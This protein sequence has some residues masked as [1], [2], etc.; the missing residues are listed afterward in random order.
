MISLEIFG[1]CPLKVAYKTQLLSSIYIIFHII[2][3][4]VQVISLQVVL[5]H[6]LGT[7][8]ENF[9]LFIFSRHWRIEA[10]LRK[11]LQNYYYINLVEQV[12]KGDRIQS[13]SSWKLS[14]DWLPCIQINPVDIQAIKLFCHLC[15]QS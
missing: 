7:I 13:I 4:I 8:A 14:W 2:P 11:L 9:Y 6:D 5:K 3:S 15:T 1:G 12:D 10:H